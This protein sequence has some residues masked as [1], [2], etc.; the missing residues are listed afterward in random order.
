M[1]VENI[2]NA[3]DFDKEHMYSANDA[4]LKAILLLQYYYASFK[5]KLLD[6][7]FFYFCTNKSIVMNNLLE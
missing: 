6:E 3:N 2:E 4:R 1:R 5:I 7:F